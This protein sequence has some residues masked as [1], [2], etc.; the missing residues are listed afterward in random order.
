MTPRLFHSCSAA[1]YRPARRNNGAMGQ[2]FFLLKSFPAKGLLA[3]GL[4][5]S[6]VLMS[7]CALPLAVPPAQACEA[8]P[9]VEPELEQYPSPLDLSNITPAQQQRLE[10]TVAQRKQL[11]PYQFL[12]LYRCP[13]LSN[14]ALNAFEARDYALALSLLDRA[15]A[16]RPDSLTRWLD[17]AVVHYYLGENAAAS[18]DATQVRH[19]LNDINFP[20][21]QDAYRQL[22]I[23]LDG[24]VPDSRRASEQ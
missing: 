4:I 6:M 15:I 1:N 9:T 16:Q 19:R 18:K 2:H 12:S 5:T 3:R 14:R 20:E 10:A 13:S 24:Q 21:A 8:Q 11:L 23:Q 17:R 7:L 22:M